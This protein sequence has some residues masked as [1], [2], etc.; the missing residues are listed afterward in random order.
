[1]EQF[2]TTN[3]NINLRNDMQAYTYLQLA[4]ICFINNKTPI[5][6]IIIVLLTQMLREA[7]TKRGP[8]QESGTAK[9][10]ARSFII[11]NNIF[12]DAKSGIV[13]C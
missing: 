1:M 2:L 13:R 7:G 6:L 11:L 10:N 8:E 12:C 4:N 9:N 3:A 5:L